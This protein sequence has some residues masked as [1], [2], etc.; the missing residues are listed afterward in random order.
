MSLIQK[1]INWFKKLFGIDQP[2]PTPD[3][4]F[5]DGQDLTYI[6][7][8][9]VVNNE[10]PK[11]IYYKSIGEA[12]A[13]IAH[14]T[15]NLISYPG[16]SLLKPYFDIRYINKVSSYTSTVQH[17][18]FTG[19]DASQGVTIGT[20]A[21]TGDS[22]GSIAQYTT[23]TVIAGGSTINLFDSP[24]QILEYSGPQITFSYQL[25]STDITAPWKINKNLTL[26][27]YFSTP[28]YA[29]YEN[30]H[31]GGLNFNVFLYNKKLNKNINYV[32]G[33]YSFA[34][35]WT[36]EQSDLHF[37]TTTNIV[38]V[39]TVIKS[40]TLWSA[41]S[42][43]SNETIS[44]PSVNESVKVGQPNFFRANITYNN[45]LNVLKE[46]KSGSLDEVSNQDFGTTPEDWEV[47]F[48]AI[49]S[50]LEEYGGKAITAN[51]FKGFEVYSSQNPS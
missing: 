7:S 6:I 4:D 9:L 42:P 41:K 8:S 30:N 24:Y 48:V 12:H 37:D 43:Y 16:K 32:I 35:G 46:L 20:V 51:S 14:D 17:K 2:K 45:L 40:D 10:E 44:I 38:H 26:Q 18:N 13:N 28:Y 19:L 21:S 36:E 50:E 3:G 49:Q 5:Q 34:N 11:H 25:A 47:S 27:G 23:D 1:I 39:A 15:K 33:I 22:S 29:N 31:G